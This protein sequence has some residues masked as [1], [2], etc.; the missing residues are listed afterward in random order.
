MRIKIKK[1]QQA[2]TLLYFEF[3]TLGTIL[4]VYPQKK[5]GEGLVTFFGKN[6]GTFL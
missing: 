1:E 6:G 3:L 2:K 4:S 5:H